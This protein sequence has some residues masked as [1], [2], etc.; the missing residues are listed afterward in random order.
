MRVLQIPASQRREGGVKE[1]PRHDRAA[2]RQR[3]SR[4]RTTR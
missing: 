1:L 2:F 4:V 3:P